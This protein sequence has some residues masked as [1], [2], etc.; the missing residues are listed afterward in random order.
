MSAARAP[1]PTTTVTPLR[2]V[3][4]SRNLTLSL[5]R[6]CRCYCK[7]CAFATHQAHIHDPDAVRERLD[8][9]ARRNV[10]EL[11]VLTGESPEV[12][13]IVA[14][15]LRGWGH[16]DFTSY[17]E[18]ACEEALLRGMLPHT[19]IGVAPREHLERLRGVTA[20]QGLM[21]ESA[22]K[23]LMQTVHAGSPTKHPAV[24]LE[25]IETAGELQIPFTSGILVGIGETEE[26]R[27]ASLEAL[28]AAHERHGHIQEVILQNFVPHPRYYGAEVAD[29][30]AEASERRWSDA[31][32]A[33][34]DGGTEPE[35]PAWA[36]PVS[37]DDMR[38]LV[39][40]ARRLMP[41][42][43]VQIPPNLSDW[44]IDLVEAGATDLGGLSANGDHI[45]PE[46]PFPS[47]HQVRKEL[48]P[49]GYA[50]TER[51]CVYPQYMNEEWMDGGVLDVLERRFPT[52]LPRSR[53]RPNGNGAAPHVNGSPDLTACAVE[54]G[55]RGEELTPEE[56]TALFAERRP[57]AI[58]DMRQAADELRAELAG[59]VATFVVNRNINFTNVCTVGCAFCGFGQTRRSPDAYEIDPAEFAERIRE[60]VGF[61]ATEICMQ[62]GIHPDYELS[63]YG[64]WLQ[65]AKTVAPDIHLHA[66]SPMEVHFMCERSGKD[67][68]Y[69]FAYLR[70]RGLGS[71]PGTAAEVL[72]DGVRQRISPNKLPADRWVE[73]IEAS[74]RAGLRSTSTVMFGHIE[75]PRELAEHMRVVRSLQERTGGI[76]E[77]V[78][79]SFIPYHTMLGRTHGIEEISDEENLKH[80]AVFRLALGRTIPN[81][82]ASW[83]K[84]GLGAAT[85]ALRWGVNDLGGTLMEESISRMAGSQHGS[86]LEPED[87]ITAARRAGRTP[88]QRNTLYEV[89]ETY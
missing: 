17:V 54:R 63:D 61:G 58:E 85:E 33:G 53:P 5:S 72:E 22:S 86:R 48:R 76:T 12:N 38:R 7:Y 23:R 45:S 47:P 49:R 60:A 43:G 30:A 46:H 37:L 32:G 79:L 75:R 88:A 1:I 64:E 9:A 28:A 56:L 74:H 77:F 73:I 78:P 80:T 50:L 51:L 57:E 65:R 39:A 18:W 84:M 69:V 3:T 42:V 70:E 41:D 71:T 83:V 36:S 82:Q 67:P 52:F 20:S 25:T 81:L 40:E 10:K 68:D 44:W 26:E 13:P 35:F 66:Y 59:D 19:N 55:R 4:F 87:L 16:E 2:R 31:E 8:E 89:L 24:R 34:A 11:L 29:I 6:T 21:L 15:R 14:E 62:G 27:V